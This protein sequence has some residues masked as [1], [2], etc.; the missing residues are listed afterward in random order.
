M[1]PLLCVEVLQLWGV[2]VLALVSCVRPGVEL[3]LG[4][5]KAVTSIGF[6]SNI[7]VSFVVYSK[8]Q[9]VACGKKGEVGEFQVKGWLKQV[10][11]MSLTLSTSDLVALMSLSNRSKVIWD[12][13]ASLHSRSNF[14]LLWK[15]S[16]R[17]R[18]AEANYFPSL[19]DLIFQKV[20]KML[21]NC[22]KNWL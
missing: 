5:N 1:L 7:T 17:K 20:S 14:F 6:T 10:L 22:N 16:Q 3:V 13:S 4:L 18:E 2:L 8:G 21:P 19:L 11:Q 9:T 12:F 15:Q